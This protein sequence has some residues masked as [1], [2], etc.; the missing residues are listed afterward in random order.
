[1]RA[2]LAAILSHPLAIDLLDDLATLLLGLL[3]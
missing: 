3:N 2:D 1:M